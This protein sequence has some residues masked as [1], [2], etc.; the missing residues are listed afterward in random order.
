MQRTEKRYVD[1]EALL[2]QG[3]TTSGGYLHREELHRILATLNIESLVNFEKLWGALDLKEDGRIEKEEWRRALM[4]AKTRAQDLS[5]DVETHWK[6]EPE[7]EGKEGGL[8]GLVAHNKMKRQMVSFVEDNM[9][10]FRK[11]RIVTTGTTGRT[12][13]ESL[14]LPVA[15]KVA[16][17]PLGGDQEIGAL[18]TQGKV[19]AIFFFKDPLTAHQHHADIEALSRI[20]DVHDVPYACNESSALGILYAMTNLG[21]DYYGPRRKS[22]CVEE[23]EKEQAEVRE[24]TTQEFQPPRF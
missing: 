19:K 21:L 17:G 2:E 14:G 7:Y 6:D 10:F 12:L 1:L 9:D 11:C 15:L 22:E 13:E 16:S 8:V 20:C 4:G 3:D 5:R 23:Y 18:V 24:R